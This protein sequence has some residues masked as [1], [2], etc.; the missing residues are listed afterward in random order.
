M[1]EGGEHEPA[2]NRKDKGSPATGHQ[3]PRPGE[4]SPSFK[5][6]TQQCSQS[7]F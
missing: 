6:E 4:W 1:G 5:K 7:K 2:A 3:S